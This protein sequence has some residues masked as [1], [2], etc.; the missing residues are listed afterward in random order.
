[1]VR[2]IFSPFY[3]EDGKL[4]YPAMQPGSEVMAVQKL[5]AG[6]PFSYSDV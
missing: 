6:A 3:G 2:E 5:Y 4:V 1:M